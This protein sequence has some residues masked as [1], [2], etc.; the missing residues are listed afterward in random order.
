MQVDEVIDVL[1]DAAGEPLRFEWRGV[2]H[3]VTGM[4]E[5]WVGRRPWWREAGR[6]PRRR[7]LMPLETYRWRVDAVCLTGGGSDGSEPLDGTYD[8]A[9]L[10]ERGWVLMTASRERQAAPQFV[11]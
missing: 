10:P 6:A 4:P 8:I 9:F 3:G 5:P 2:I 1:T 11:S 7:G